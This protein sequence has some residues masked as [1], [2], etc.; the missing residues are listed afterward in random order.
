VGVWNEQVETVVDDEQEGDDERLRD[1][2]PVYAGED[3]DAVWAEDRYRCH[4]YVV[5]G[6]EIEE[7]S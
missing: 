7:R 2:D 4:V 1:L 6:A 3:V 5:E